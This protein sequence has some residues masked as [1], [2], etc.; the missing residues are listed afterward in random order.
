MRYR[1][2]VSIQEDGKFTLM[3]LM[4]EN[5]EEQTILSLSNLESEAVAEYSGDILVANYLKE[6]ADLQNQ[7]ELNNRKNHLLMYGDVVSYHDWNDDRGANRIYH[8]VDEKGMAH[9]IL[10]KNGD[11]ITIT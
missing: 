11:V 3:I 10:M 6:Y 8:I 2:K 7:I 4:V 5:G 9:T 1:H